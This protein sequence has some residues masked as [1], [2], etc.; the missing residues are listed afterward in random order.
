MWLCSTSPAVLPTANAA[1]E[2]GGG[3]VT[4][5]HLPTP[6]GSVPRRWY[7]QMGLTGPEGNATAV[8]PAL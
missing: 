6:P 3:E 5:P 7:N 1:A 2:R 8:A 4:Q